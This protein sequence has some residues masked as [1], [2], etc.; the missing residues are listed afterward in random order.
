VDEYRRAGGDGPRYGQMTVCW[1]ES[2]AEARRLAGEVW[3]NGGLPGDLSQ[4][5]HQI[6][7]DQDGFL[8]F[9]E[10]ELLGRVEVASAR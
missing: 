2:E 10:R 6:G 9:A 5:L 4:E 8:R 3:P 1:N 7:P